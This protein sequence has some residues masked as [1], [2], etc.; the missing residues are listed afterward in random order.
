[1]NVV[2]RYEIHDQ[3]GSES[4][5]VVYDGELHG[6]PQGGGGWS[7]VGARS[8]LPGKFKKLFDYGQYW[9]CT[10]RFHGTFLAICCF[11][12]IRGGGAFFGIAAPPPPITNISA[13]AYDHRYC[14]YM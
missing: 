3:Y 14:T 8:I 6:C 7:R 9:A 13:G 1:M 12:L 5:R 11:F 2:L 10:I 4:S